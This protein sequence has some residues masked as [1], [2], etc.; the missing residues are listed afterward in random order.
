MIVYHAY[1]SNKVPINYFLHA[2]LIM[3][4]KISIN[5]IESKEK[6]IGLNLDMLCVSISIWTFLVRCAI[7][8]QLYTL[9]IWHYMQLSGLE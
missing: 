8:R 1:S 2:F 7:M 4:I 3:F 9:E 5:L 6:Y